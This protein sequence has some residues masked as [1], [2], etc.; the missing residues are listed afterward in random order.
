MP[1]PTDETGTS[2]LQGLEYE[3]CVEIID[4]NGVLSNVEWVPELESSGDDVIDFPESADM[5]DN[6]F[7]Y[8]FTID[9]IA[10]E[11]DPYSYVGCA[12]ATESDEFEMYVTNVMEQIIIRGGG[13]PDVVHGVGDD[14]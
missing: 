4:D 10:T 9:L 11:D 3:D 6:V 7:D 5:P 13:R 2:K 1:T 14:R 12:V 8:C